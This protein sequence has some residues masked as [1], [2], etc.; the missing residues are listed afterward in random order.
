MGPQHEPHPKP[1]YYHPIHDSKHIVTQMSCVICT[2]VML[3]S[4]EE[5]M[6]GMD[7]RIA[8]VLLVRKVVTGKSQRGTPGFWPIEINSANLAVHLSVHNS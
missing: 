1:G 6:G 3:V 7:G 4:A 5:W 2:V 8:N